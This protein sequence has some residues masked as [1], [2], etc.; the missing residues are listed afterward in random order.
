MTERIASLA[1][2][3]LL[4]A[5]GACA[6]PS[7]PIAPPP[8]SAARLAE[9]DWDKAT[10]VNVV[11]SEFEFSPATVRL[12]A[13]E[14]YRLRLENRGG[15]AHTFTA[16][17]FFAAAAVRAGAMASEAQLSGGTIELAA[18]ETKEIELVPLR[19]GQYPLECSRPLHAAFGMTGEIVVE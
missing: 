7:R 12:K 1:A 19:P 11:L 4:L 15:S 5:L 10:P 17:D 6:A 3:L 9:V 13:G 16:P 14:P 8:E 18:G 2:T